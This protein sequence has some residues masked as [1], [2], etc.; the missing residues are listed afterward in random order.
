MSQLLAI[1]R[2]DA[3]RLWP[4]VLLG[5]L[6]LGILSAIDNARR[7]YVPALEESVCSALLPLLWC[8]LI[9]YLVHLESP[10]SANPFWATRPYRWPA[11]IGAKLLFVL[12]FIHIPLLVANAAVLS[13]HGFVPWQHVHALLS[14][15][16][17][18]A[19]AL[20]L[21]ALALASITRTL[22]QAGGIALLL[23]VLATL[24]RVKALP[25]AYPWV[26]LELDSLFAALTC[27]TVAA[28]VL[29][30]LQYARRRTL[31]A[32][33]IGM[34]ATVTAAGVFVY[35][36]RELT[37]SLR[38]TESNTVRLN[39]RP[40]ES[41]ENNP[42]ARFPF[43][44]RTIRV[45]VR[46]EGIQTEGQVTAEILS[47]Q[48]NDARDFHWVFNPR[49]AYATRPGPREAGFWIAD[50]R[51]GWLTIR[52]LKTTY[53]AL[54]DA[55][56]H[57]QGVAAV[58]EYVSSTRT[59]MPLYGPARDARSVG[60]CASQLTENT[61]NPY[62]GEMLK[63]L[64]ES[65]EPLP[66]RVDIQLSSASYAEPWRQFLGDAAGPLTYPAINWLSPL[67]RRQTFFHVSPRPLDQPSGRYL[68][69][70]GALQD[71]QLT[72]IPWRESR[73]LVVPFSFSNL[74]LKEGLVQ[75]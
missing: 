67:H 2:K 3:R 12:V 16:L 22:A 39:L 70:K 47:L 31:Q 65:P 44:I 74:S 32:R 59:S 15:Q 19:A 36:P 11:L 35:L 30:V 33:V 9:V 61:T 26:V 71:A 54:K 51:L 75:D 24:L 52:M 60:R 7:D 41:S 28:V 5:V 72:F 1:F 48:V 27:V 20:T 40:S 55:R 13:A 10:A 42:P 66:R 17:T 45:P 49:A 57:V 38:A 46:L 14:L 53:E 64:C 25:P 56:I 69:P 4:G 8:G 50:G 34:A 21:P 58:N 73:R 29:F 43:A 68:V 23:I 18:V 37:A 6:L 63:V 62:G